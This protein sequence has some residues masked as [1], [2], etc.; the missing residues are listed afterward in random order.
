[1]KRKSSDSEKKPLKQTGLSAFYKFPVKKR[2]RTSVQMLT[3]GDRW[4]NL[5][6]K[7]NK[8]SRM[9]LNKEK[10]S[11]VDAFYLPESFLDTTASFLDM[12]ELHPD[13][14][15]KVFIAG[16]ERSTPRYQQTY[17]YSYKF[18]GMDHECLPIP[19]EIVPFLKWANIQEYGTLYGCKGYNQ[20]IINWYEPH[21][22][23][24]AHS[25]DEHQL[26]TSKNAET[27]VWSLTLLRHDQLLLN[28]SLRT[29][30]IKPKKKTKD[31]KINT[32]SLDIR[33]DH[34]LVLVMGGRCQREY[35]HQVVKISSKTQENTGDRINITFRCFKKK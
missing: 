32:D 21:H 22:H 10:T 18:S 13:E 17:G 12:W 15:G 3:R 6:H 8:V 4:G 23:I 33:L 29:F 30:R 31:Q 14:Y 34:G 2:F 26:V 7:D 25:D 19:K 35:T 16:K 28:K 24:G 5:E 27:T 1:M 20:V 11:W 9:W